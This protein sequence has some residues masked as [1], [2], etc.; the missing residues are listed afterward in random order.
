MKALLAARTKRPDLMGKRSQSPAPSS[1][2]VAAAKAAHAAAKKDIS[3]DD[4][5]P[6][7]LQGAPLV[8]EEL[9]QPNAGYSSDSDHLRPSERRGR[10]LNRSSGPILL[11][12]QTHS[13]LDGRL[14]PAQDASESSDS[15]D[16]LEYAEQRWES[17]SARPG[18]TRSSLKA[19]AEA[20]RRANPG[21]QR[22]QRKSVTKSRLQFESLQKQWQDERKLER[23]ENGRIRGGER[24][25]HSSD[26]LARRRTKNHSTHVTIAESS[27]RDSTFRARL[28]EIDG[29]LNTVLS[30]SEAGKSGSPASKFP[31]RRR[32]D[33]EEELEMAGQQAEVRKR[34]QKLER[35]MKMERASRHVAN[36]LASAFSEGADSEPRNSSFGREDRA[37][38]SV[39]ARSRS[40]LEKQRSKSPQQSPEWIARHTY[41]SMMKARPTMLRQEEEDVCKNCNILHTLLQERDDKI[42][43]LKDDLVMA[44]AIRKKVNDSNETL[45][46]TIDALRKQ[47]L[48]SK[49][50]LAKSVDVCCVFKEEIA[51][52]ASELK[53]AD[54]ALQQQSEIVHNL[55]VEAEAKVRMEGMKE[56]KWSNQIEPLE[57][58]LSS[59]KRSRENFDRLNGQV[60]EMQNN[61]QT[62][63]EYS[64]QT[65]L[66]DK[67][68]KLEKKIAEM[69]LQQKEDGQTFA[70]NFGRGATRE[71]ELSE[72]NRQQKKD[73]EV[74]LSR[75]SEIERGDQDLKQSIEEMATL[76]AAVDSYEQALRELR[77]ERD[78]L[79]AQQ[80]ASNTAVDSYKRAL[81]TANARHLALEASN[82]SL[83]RQIAGLGK[84]VDNTEAELVKNEG[85]N[86]KIQSLQQVKSV[87][88][89]TINELSESALKAS[90]GQHRKF[91]IERT[92]LQ[93][94]AMQLTE[95]PDDLAERLRESL[96]VREGEGW[97]HLQQAQESMVDLKKY[98]QVLEDE[99]QSLQ[100]ARCAD[101]TTIKVLRESF[102]L[103]QSE[104][105]RKV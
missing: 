79:G 47:K 66:T 4:E 91:V 2:L 63:R 34:T 92:Q 17:K 38:F 46:V 58:Q 86:K 96:Q 10:S 42:R 98:V 75:N 30:S 84:K 56:E 76:T 54:I 28:D 100:K 71:A 61:L 20:A 102:D 8:A 5:R 24:E 11:A 16:R 43:S 80:K 6:I 21:R 101:A 37:K 67:V 97:A 49:A 62:Q 19:R 35:E 69:L 3:S 104:H 9:V 53:D 68:S 82:T 33:S 15:D 78:A 83:Q 55:K 22:S 31:L 13:G 94:Q 14:I 50:Q 39:Q 52:F 51:N 89:M 1:S 12:R 60:V 65:Q 7:E 70:E 44:D 95:E 64:V 36:R 57:L 87:Y 88:E 29:M 72:K 81:E 40:P 77:A 93:E 85:L 105:E 26:E 23:E 41:V 90:K 74:A 27:F 18:S 99:R 59:A 48:H 73:L 32:R 45:E 25:N 103:V